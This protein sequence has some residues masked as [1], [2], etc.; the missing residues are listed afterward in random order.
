[1]RQRTRLLASAI[2]AVVVLSPLLREPTSD[3]YPL[4][5]YPMFAGDR[6]AVHQIATAVERLPGG[7]IARLSP[8]LIAGTDEVILAAVTVQRALASGEGDALCGEIAARLGAG[9]TVEVRRETVDVVAVIADD[10]APL[11]VEVEATCVG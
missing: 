8:D 4:S 1:M 3:T 5:T 7:G 9:R 11:H 2:A 10:A 6:G